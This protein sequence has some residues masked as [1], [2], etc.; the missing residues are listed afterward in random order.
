M[1]FRQWLS[2]TATMLAATS[3]SHVHAQTFPDRPIKLLVGYAPGGPVDSTAR[4]FA[5]Y[6]SEAMKTTIVV[7][8]K[9]GAGAVIAADATAKAT[10]DGYTLNFV[11][12]P[13][14]TISPIV[15][16]TK[17]FDPR[18]DFSYIGSVVHYANVLVVGP[19]LPVN[20]VKEL[21]AYAKKNPQ[22]VS[23]GSAGVGSS[24]HL[25]G[26]LL[27]QAEDVSM[28]HVPYKGSNPAMMDVIGGKTGYMFDIPIQANVQILAGKVKPLAVTSRTRNPSLPNVPTM[29]EAGIADFE[30]IGWFALM[31]P[32]ALPKDVFT[33][34]EKGLQNVAANAEF[35]AAIEKAGFQLVVENSDA[36]LAR[37]TREYAMWEKVIQKAKIN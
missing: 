25:S 3:F 15:Q 33:K 36:M 26:E 37:V 4:I 7:E 20:N 32:K 12:S 1:K 2:V 28:L 27:A 6:F 16:K 10:P 35:K 17:A 14:I 21:V 22:G 11:A 18:T 13:A 29:I 5:R 19:A 23:Y 34:L 8:N 30:V 9:P 31:G 24:N